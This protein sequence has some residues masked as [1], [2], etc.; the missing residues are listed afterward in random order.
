MARTLVELQREL[1]YEREKLEKAEAL[2]DKAFKGEPVELMPGRSMRDLDMDIRKSRKTVIRLEYLIAR[3]Q[4]K[5][6]TGRRDETDAPP[7]SAS[8]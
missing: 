8:L 5:K 3:K 4:I 7:A 2:M 6:E 1:D